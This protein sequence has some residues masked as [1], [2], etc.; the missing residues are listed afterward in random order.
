VHHVTIVSDAPAPPASTTGEVV[1]HATNASTV[2]GNWRVTP[3]SSAA[4]GARMWLPDAALPKLGSP[5]AVPGDYFEL[6]F[7]AEAGRA[8]RLWMRGRADRDSWANDSA[9][10][11]FSGSVTA[12]GVPVYRIG[13]DSATWLGVEDCS[14]CA[15]NGWGWQD[16]GYGAGVLGPVVYFAA[17]G[18]QTLRVQRRED[19]LSIDQIV[20]SPAVY[21]TSSPGVTTGDTTIM[22]ATSAAAPVVDAAEIVVTASA[23]TT[24]AGAWRVLADA[25][26]SGGTAVGHPDA[27]GAKLP[28]A[29]AAP[30]NYVEFR[31]AAEAGRVYRLWLRGRADRDSWA[32]DSVFVQFD[33]AIAAPAQPVARIGTTSAFT[34]NLEED[35]GW[36]VSGW[37]WQDNGYGAGVLGPLVSFETTGPQTIR[38]QTREDGLRIDQIV[39]S[40]SQFLTT[41]PGAIRNDTTIVR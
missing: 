26:A 9:F 6:R 27:G 38:I 18:P 21:L 8:Y 23:V 20:L 16:N 33:G 41:A 22:A 34:V 36:G 12:A 13:T 31:F 25:S 1:L 40:S 7:T 11:Q 5:L 28:A 37:G 39:L 2:A 15:M 29:M 30:V 3:D 32:N 35:S 10:F 17:S 24:V 19:G 4:G 14:G